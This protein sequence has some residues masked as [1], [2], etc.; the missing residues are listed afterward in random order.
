MTQPRKSKILPR[1]ED[2]R[3]YQD[4]D[5]RD[6]WPYSDESGLSSPNPENREYG[7]TPANFDEEPNSGVIGD[8]ADADGLEEDTAYTMGPLPPSRIDND[9][10]EATI[11]ERLIES[12]DIDADSIEVHADNG[13]VTLEGSVE[14]QAVAEQAEALGLSTPG[15]VKVHNNLKTISV[16]S[17]IPPD[18]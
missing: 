11:T 10:L 2:Y 12:K 3:D 14:T 17:H 4:R 15:V 8:T 9:E 7:T 13:I 6:G 5:N 18:V 1:E 16:D